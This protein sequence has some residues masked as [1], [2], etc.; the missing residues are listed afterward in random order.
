[1]NCCGNCCMDRKRTAG[2]LAACLLALLLAALLD[3]GLGAVPIRISDLLAGLRQGGESVESRI[4]LQIRVPRLLAAVLAGAALAVCGSVLQT[5]LANPLASPG[6]IGVNAGAG[7]AD[8]LCIALL[9]HRTGLLPLASFLGGL[10]T[11][12][13]VYGI[14]RRAGASRITLILSGV[15]VSSLMTAGINTLTTVF[16]DLLSDLHDFQTGGFSGVSLSALFTAGPV[17]LGGILAVLL[18]ADELDVLSLGEST[19]LSLGLN[20]PVYRFL[21]L[22]LVAA[23]SGAAVSFAGL[24]GFV[25]LIVPHIVR[26]LMRGAG[27]RALIAA[28]A[29]IGA[30]FLVL[31]DTAARTLFAPFELPVGILIA[32]LGVPFFLRLLFGERR[33]RHD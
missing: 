31:C 16:P 11:V 32:Y 4:L 7:L 33:K 18:F 30:A 23:L 8:V 10:F 22:V 1:M 13:L 24:L 28:D 19:A 21:F 17:I 20:V 2:I 15:A 6:I 29:L 3:L 14:A 25:G 27:R 12:L 26:L 5:V 9:P